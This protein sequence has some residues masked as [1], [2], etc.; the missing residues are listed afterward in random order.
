MKTQQR[1]LVVIGP[2]AYVVMWLLVLLHVA[3]LSTR[4]AVMS[5]TLLTGLYCF[6][7]ARLKHRNAVLWATLGALAGFV[8]LGL[9]PVVLVGALPS[10]S[11]A[12]ADGETNRA[13]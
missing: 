5:L 9:L 4:A 1:Y 10:S 11:G 13:T 8:E 12:V 7:M 2:M 3:D 6:G